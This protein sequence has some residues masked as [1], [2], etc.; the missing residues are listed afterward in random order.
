MPTLTYSRTKSWTF[1]GRDYEYQQLTRLCRLPI[2]NI[3]SPPSGYSFSR[4]TISC[5]IKWGG[6]RDNGKNSEFIINIAPDIYGAT[7]KKYGGY[8]LPGNTYTTINWGATSSEVSIASGS[9]LFIYNSNLNN[10]QKACITGTISITLYWTKSISNVSAGDIITKE[11]FDAIGW[12]ATKG[13]AISHSGY[14]GIIYASTYNGLN[15]TSSGDT[16]STTPQN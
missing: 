16:V 15:N 8:I 6:Q 3:W 13:S 5:N 9:Y 7:L 4:S 1:D 12:S 10:G 2:S 14:S 11:Q